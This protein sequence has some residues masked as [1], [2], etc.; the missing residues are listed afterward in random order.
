M[1]DS[2][3]ATPTFGLYRDSIKGCCRPEEATVGF[4][5]GKCLFEMGDA[6]VLL[7]CCGG[8]G[9][10]SPKTRRPPRDHFHDLLQMYTVAS[11]DLVRSY[12]ELV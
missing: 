7:I 5:L 6:A 2:L 11:Y 1:K 3:R 12:E 4:Q 9:C 10:G 8:A